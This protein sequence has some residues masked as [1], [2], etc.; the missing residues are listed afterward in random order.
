M[1][2]PNR[3][4]V[5]LRP[6]VALAAAASRANLRPLYDTPSATEAFG[7]SSEPAWYL[8]DLPDLPDGGQTPWDAAHAQVADQLGIDESAVVFAEPDLEQSFPDANETNHGGAAFAAAPDC[9]AIPQLDTSKRVKGP[10][11]FAWHLRDDFSQLGSARDLVKFEDPRTRIAHIDTGYDRDHVACPEHVRRE[12][13]RSF[14][15]GDNQPNSAQDPNR[16]H[17]IPDNSGHGTGTIGILA[18]R[19]IAAQNNIYLGGAPEA[20]I[21]PLRISNSVLLFLTSAFAKALQYAVEQRCDVV[22]ISMGGLPSKAWSEAVDNAYEKGICIVAAAGNSYGGLPTHHVV[23]PARYRRT[24]AACGVM[25]DGHP[26]Y[27]LDRNALEGNW[28]PDSSMSAALASYTPNIPWAVFGCKTTLRLNGEGTSAATPQIAAAVALWYEK[29]KS[30]LPRDWQRVEAVRRALFTSAQPGDGQY[31]GHG[32]LRA[33][34]ALSVAP[35]FN[36]DKTK[37]DNDSFSFLRVITGLGIADAP[38]PARETMFNL[39]LTQLWLLNPALQEIVPDPDA[40]VLPDKMRDFMEGA[41]RKFMDA[42]I[43]DKNASLALR[44]HVASRYPLVHGTPAKDIPVEVMPPATAACDTKVVINDPPFRRLRTYAVDP[45]FSTRLDTASI[46]EVVLKVRWEKSLEP[47]PVGEYLEVVDD[48]AAGT[49]YPPVDLNDPRLLAQDGC[50]PAEGNPAFHQQ[51]VYAIAMKTIEHFEH[52]L[53]RPVLWRPGIDPQNKVD[54]SQFVQRLKVHPHALHQANAY[55]SP[56]EIAL[57]FGYFQAAADDPGDHVPGSTVYACLSHDIVAH[58]TTHA[59]LDG[60]HRRFNEASN[61]DVLALHEAF[62]DIV[63]L[64]QHFTIPEILENEIGR[65]RGNLEAESILGSLAVQFGR[66]TGGRGA[67][68]DAIGTLDENGKWMRLK[69]DPS[70]LQK[71]TMP[72]ARGALLVAAVFDAFLAIY[73]GRIADLLR[74]Y[75]GGTGVLPSGSIHPDL[76]RR[77]A[78]EASKSAQHVLN[79]CIRALDYVPPV[80]VTFGEYLRGLITADFDLV[81]DDHYDY[82]V[83]FVEAFRKRGIYPH[84]LDR[85]TANTLSVDTLRWQGFSLSFLTKSQGRSIEKLIVN[86]KRYADACLYISDRKVLFERTRKQR[87]IV[88]DK[89]QDILAKLPDATRVM[90]ASSLGL[91]PTVKFE[92]HELRPSLRTGPDGRHVPQ[93][94]VALTQ[95]LRVEGDGASEPHTFRGGSTLV[96]DLL[97]RVIKYAIVKNFNSPQ[98]RAASAAFLKE[99]RQD[100][101]RALLV[102]PD[103]AEPFAA[104]HSLA[105][106]GGF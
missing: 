82:R 18:G 55:Y 100:P 65:T 3:I 90:F 68:R 47:G 93:I 89:L 19:Q 85:L 21:V 12:L 11:Q 103:R 62:A 101:L 35:V 37:S 14:V 7:L 88:H 43:A 44:K 20:D 61:P 27:N 92:V 29:Y 8:A 58:E 45:S 105:D 39:E 81:E 34:D 74:I 22:S 2:N 9:T 48:D 78:G 96:V 67:L 38:A 63:A 10:D 69:A 46:N 16:G 94:I 57:R 102:A 79:M 91:D 54:D 28:G 98:R 41:G 72:H 66:A 95:E 53:G 76:V 86:L 32:I 49:H 73:E 70:A 6:T 97:E 30:I 52:A 31:I 24:I 13:E 60:M 33:N 104:L 83:A 56:Q 40:E 77:L 15:D 5:K 23:Y 4:L 17:A 64:M 59:I 84:D 106:V 80:D 42:V 25:A 71:E 99:M 1:A 50:P 87:E 51:T 26:Y 36:L 75:T